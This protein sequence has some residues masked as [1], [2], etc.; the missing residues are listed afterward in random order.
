MA[1]FLEIF[2]NRSERRVLL[3]CVVAGFVLTGCC[4]RCS[5]VSYVRS[6]ELHFF[7]GEQ[8]TALRDFLD[9]KKVFMAGKSVTNQPSLMLC[10]LVHW[11]HWSK[12]AC[13][14]QM[15]IPIIWQV[16]SL[17]F[18][19]SALFQIFCQR[20]SSDEASGTSGYVRIRLFCLRF[21]MTS[22]AKTS[23]W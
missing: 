8:W 2:S 18:K 6:G 1:S 13:D 21:R 14:R 3:P 17:F 9:G 4:C 12:L 10:H 20:D 7:T 16:F 23:G 11:S 15:I 5:K 22:V 19:M